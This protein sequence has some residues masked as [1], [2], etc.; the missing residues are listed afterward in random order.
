MPTLMAVI[1][2][3]RRVYRLK[4]LPNEILDGIK[5]AKMDPSHDHL[6]ALL[7]DK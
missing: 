6:N 7:E 2:G 5:S 3:E 4:E 1:E